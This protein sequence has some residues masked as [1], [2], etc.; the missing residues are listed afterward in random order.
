[1]TPC[2]PPTC[3]PGVGPEDQGQVLGNEV[4]TQATG[5]LGSFAQF[6]EVVEDLIAQFRVSDAAPTAIPMPALCSP[7]RWE[8]AASSARDSGSATSWVRP[9]G[10]KLNTPRDP[11]PAQ[12]RERAWM[13]PEADMAAGRATSSRAQRG[14]CELTRTDR[15]ATV[16]TAPTCPA[17]RR[18]AISAGPML[19]TPG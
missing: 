2:P 7:I 18:L 4:G 17:W 8:A 5:V 6:D 10:P 3:D 11:N 15:S 13:Y 16:A 1:M 12:N 9:T 14:A 19:H